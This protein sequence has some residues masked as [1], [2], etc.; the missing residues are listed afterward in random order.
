M[1]KITENLRSSRF[2]PLMMSFLVI[3]SGLLTIF[4][5]S[6][7]INSYDLHDYIEGV[8]W[9]EATLK[10]GSLINP[11]YVYYYIVPLGS[12]VIM[13]PFV[14]LFGL[15]LLA[16]ELGMIVYFVIFLAVLYRLSASLY[17]EL[18]Y[19]LVFCT[20]S[21]LFIY[22]YIGD[23]LLHHIISY[24]IGY[25]CFLGQLSCL[26]DIRKGRNVRRSAVLLV[27]LSF[28]AASNGIVTAALSVLPVMLGLFL[29]NYRSGTLLK[30]EDL[31]VCLPVIIPA[32]AG[33]VLYRVCDSKALSLNMYEAR[34]LLNDAE[35]LVSSMTGRILQDY[36][37]IFYFNPPAISAFSLNGIFYLIKLMFAAAVII[38]PVF[39]YA[40][41]RKKGDRPFAG[42]DRY[43]TAAACFITI[44]I[45]FAQYVVFRRVTQ[46]YLFNG[47]LS[48]F[49]L[50]ALLYADQLKRSGKMTGT[51]VLSLFVLMYTGKM[52]VFT[53]PE[54]SRYEKVYLDTL[55][56]LQDNG[57]TY[58]YT[59]GR[60]YQV[61]ELY[62]NGEYK[63]YK[64]DFDDEAD[65]Y[66]I[67]YDRIYTEELKRPEGID[68]FYIIRNTPE[69]EDKPR[70]VLLE[71]NYTEKT[72][73]GVNN[74][75]V[76]PIEDWDKVMIEK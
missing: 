27:I 33:I 59:I 20:V 38:L 65:R 49:L 39:L 64:L 44:L 13:A 57:L 2:L 62:T 47:I 37:K 22:T 72:V 1:K 50:L 66:Y 26:I 10:S 63:V 73:I 52:L 31:R 30:K 12:N 21:A 55:A 71:N 40:G 4:T 45:S 67:S 60:N 24:G 19:R 16:N 68:R 58:G 7:G 74:I 36:L 32:I 17:A 54:S 15:S 76:F 8:F 70:Y 48:V 23:N 5:F 69:D 6:K 41:N 18:R 75:Y 46:R 11:E 43:M 28:W 61:M 9:A 42:E 53:F 35:G 56:Y 14:R 29:A 3:V 51:M 34:F 25:V